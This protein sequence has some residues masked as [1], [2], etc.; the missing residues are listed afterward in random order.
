MHRKLIELLELERAAIISA[1]FDKIDLLASS[2]QALFGRLLAQ[3]KDKKSLIEIHTALLRNQSL[4]QSAI[5]GVSA[6][7]TRLGALRE[8]RDNLRVYDQSGR[9]A[10]VVARSPDLSKRS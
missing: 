1:D 9:M 5:D 7:R 2:K 3:T 10:Q 8:V 6:A 4:F